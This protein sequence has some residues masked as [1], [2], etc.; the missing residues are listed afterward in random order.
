MPL[1]VFDGF[2]GLLNKQKISYKNTCNEIRH[3]CSYR[4]NKMPS[5]DARQQVLLDQYYKKLILVTG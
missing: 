1:N 5:R 2:G 3:P 4:L